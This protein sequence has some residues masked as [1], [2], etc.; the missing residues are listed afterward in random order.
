MNTAMNKALHPM[1]NGFSA[2][3]TSEGSSEFTVILHPDGGQ[4]VVEQ[5]RELNDLLTDAL[6][7]NELTR[8]D[9][10]FTRFFLSD[11]AN[12][13]SQL[14]ASQ[15]F[16]QLP[17][18]SKSIVGQAPLGGGLIALQAYC[19]KGQNVTVSRP[20]AN[21][22]TIVE[23]DAYQHIWCGGM[24]ASGSDS[25]AQTDG[26][27]TDYETAMKTFGCTMNPDLIRTWIYVHDVDRNYGGMVVARRELFCAR[28]LCKKTNYVAST[29]IEARLPGADELVAMDAVTVKGLSKDQVLFLQAPDNMCPTHVY[30]VTFER[31]TKVIYGDREH[32]YVSGT[33]SIDVN[34]DVLHLGD[35]ARQTGRTLDNVEALVSPH[36]CD[37]GDF[38]HLLIYL[39]NP[40]QYNDVRRV[41]D[42]RVPSTVPRIYLHGPVCRPTWLVEIE[43]IALKKT[44]APYKNF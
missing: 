18:A 14:I 16:E 39:R 41:V 29:G 30:D 13:H 5:L 19:V 23:T 27:F 33:A 21:G 24:T 22:P 7:A 15:L 1:K 12:Q 37:L 35:V 40:L 31:G 2:F 38:S 42:Q 25:H 6:V 20:D 4:S 32:I 44:D 36:G 10:V 43:G 11:I 26:I 34:G 17:V 9:V 8:G 28:D 3:E